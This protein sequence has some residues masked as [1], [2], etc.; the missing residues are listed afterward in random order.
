M[1]IV[2]KINEINLIHFMQNFNILVVRNSSKLFQSV[3]KPDSN[4]SLFIWVEFLLKIR[5]PRSKIA[6][7]FVIIY[8][9]KV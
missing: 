9:H 7:F 2:H 4:G 3:T 1:K 6:H 5:R 8:F